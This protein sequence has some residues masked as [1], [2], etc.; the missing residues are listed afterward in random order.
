MKKERF[1]VR[2]IQRRACA[3]QNTG[4]F[5]GYEHIQRTVMDLEDFF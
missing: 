2:D 4:G 3:R 5:A 1:T